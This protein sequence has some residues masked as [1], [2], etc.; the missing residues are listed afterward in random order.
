[1]LRDND[2]GGC[3]K[4]NIVDINQPLRINVAKTG[5]SVE[6]HITRDNKPLQ[7][8]IV[9]IDKTLFCSISIVCS[10][11]NDYYLRVLP[12]YIWL[13]PNTLESWFEVRSNV[14]WQIYKEE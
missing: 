2:K 7:C 9:K 13:D 1:M 5:D 6:C 12:D 10:V 14:E 4:V 3:L 11:N 8:S